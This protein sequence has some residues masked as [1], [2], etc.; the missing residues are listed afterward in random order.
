MIFM[1]DFRADSEALINEELKAV[2]R[3]LRSGWYVLGE[4]V[5]SFESEWAAR[6]GIA[7]AIGT[8]NGLDA[9]ETGIRALGLSGGD[10]VITTPMTAFATVLG[11]MRAGAT[12]ILADIDPATGLL[13]PRSV[14]R[15]ITPRSKAVLL[16]HLYGQIRDMD[17][18]VNLCRTHKIALIEDCAQ[19]HLAQWNGHGGGSFGAWGTY[20]FYPTK[21]LGAPG[22]AGALV[23]NDQSVAERARQIRNYGQSS[24]YVHS[25]VGMN[26]RLDEIHAAILRARLAWLDGFTTRRREIANRYLQGIG[27]PRIQLLARPVEMANHVYHLF[28][29]LSQE[30]DRLSS[31]LRERQIESISHYPVPVHLQP[32]AREMGRDPFG[33]PNAERHARACLSI[34]CHPNMSDAH[35]DAVI[36]SLNE[37]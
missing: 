28:V 27:N 9:I 11:I 4:E 16:V 12:P 17:V 26:S 35:V 24:R 18:W 31:F 8:G 30:R 13:D 23:T 10:E 33:L 5:R 3:V 25:V 15:C 7:Y 1:N 32:P 6:C 19:S 20:S 36:V 2:E 34:P 22:D 14:E 21:N 37:F 29:V